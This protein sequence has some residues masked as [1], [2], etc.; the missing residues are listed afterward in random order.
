MQRALCDNIARR[1]RPMRKVREKSASTFVKLEGNACAA[2]ISSI[3]TIDELV[4]RH[5]TATHHNAS[6]ARCAD[7]E[8][9]FLAMKKFS[10]RPHR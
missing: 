10:R 7:S 4:A 8:S 6:A 2:G 3:H 1:R 5:A 9:W